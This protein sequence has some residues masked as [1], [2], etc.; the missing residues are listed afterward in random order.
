MGD[1]PRA[2]PGATRRLEIA[3][4]A[5][6]AAGEIAV[7][8]FRGGY[9]TEQKADGSPVTTADRESEQAIRATIARAFPGDGVVGEEFGTT[10]GEPASVAVS[11]HYRWVID[12]I[13][14]TISFVHGVP[15]WGVLIGIERLDVKGDQGRLVAGVIHM[16]A[17]GETVYASEGGGAWHVR[18]SD[19]Q[20]IPARV[21]ATAALR[22]SLICTS[23]HE[24]WAREGLE[25]TYLAMCRTG[26]RSR[27]WTDCYAHVLVA[28]GRA[29]AVVEPSVHPWDVAAIIPIIREAGGKC[30]D[31]TGVETAASR[32]NLASNGRI[33]GELV[34]ALAD[35]KGR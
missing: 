6:T 5:A 2:D 4:E 8:Y 18:R 26:R 35:G 17:L 34:V 15:L 31:W 25:S 19:N 9:A 24:Y 30:T 28:T 14:G 16:A 11:G 10:G 33:H 32:R 21:S 22:E 12:P 13:D 23:S 1:Q 27:G 3:L 20:P 7:R 29:D